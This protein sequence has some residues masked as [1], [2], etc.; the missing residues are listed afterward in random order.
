MIGGKQKSWIG[1]PA[2]L[3]FAIVVGASV[4]FLLKEGS[5]VGELAPPSETID[6]ARAADGS[7]RI[8]AR[9]STVTVVLFTDYRC[10]ACRGSDEA[11]LQTI[12]E[13]GHAD[14]VVRPLTLFGE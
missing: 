5:G 11:L 4:S 12:D 2:G 14:L 6:K 1:G 10:P 7:P 3:A 8:L 9:S 13:D